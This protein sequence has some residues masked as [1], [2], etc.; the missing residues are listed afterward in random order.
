M[1]NELKQLLADLADWPPD[2]QEKVM[3]AILA[4]RAEYIEDNRGEVT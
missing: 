1:P 2:V 4:I 3:A